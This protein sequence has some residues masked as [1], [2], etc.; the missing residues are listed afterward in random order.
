MSSDNQE[1]NLASENENIVSNLSR[2]SLQ[3]DD[4]IDDL[5]K[6]MST[7]NEESDSE[8][9]EENLMVLSDKEDSIIDSTK[10][11]NQDVSMS[12]LNSDMESSDVNI[13]NISLKVDVDSPEDKLTE[14][15]ILLSKNSIHEHDG[16][17]QSHEN[18]EEDLPSDVQLEESDNMNDCDKEEVKEEESPCEEEKKSFDDTDLNHAVDTKNTTDSLENNQEDT[19]NEK[20][21]LLEPSLSLDDATDDQ[22]D[23]EESKSI[24]DKKDLSLEENQPNKFTDDEKNN[25]DN[26]DLEI[27]MNYTKENKESEKKLESK[28]DHSLSVGGSDADKEEH[29][30][31]NDSNLKIKDEDI[32]NESI[33]KEEALN[34]NHEVNL[35]KGDDISP[36]IHLNE[37][38]A[39][40]DQQNNDHIE[41]QDAPKELDEDFAGE[42]VQDVAKELDKEE[43][44]NLSLD[45][46]EETDEKLNLSEKNLEDNEN[47]LQDE[48]ISKEKEKKESE[49]Q[50]DVFVD[51]VSCCETK[52]EHTCERQADET[53]QS[54]DLDDDIEALLANLDGLDLDN[55]ELAND[56][57]N[58]FEPKVKDISEVKKYKFKICTS[59]ASMDRHMVSR[60]NKIIAILLAQ[61]EITEEQ[62]ELCDIGTD[63]SYKKLWYRK[64]IDVVNRNPLSLPGIFRENGTGNDDIFIGNY[65]MIYDY[66]EQFTIEEHLWPEIQDESNEEE[67]SNNILMRLLGKKM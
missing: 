22:K 53:I 60:T 61:E 59:L 67:E 3:L 26:I 41:D 19:H 65:E 10:E 12:K 34:D 50:T 9:K 54:D 35:E 52:G 8:N 39:E 56:L 51:S 27:D 13:E 36:E 64:A 44:L 2:R 47:V 45:T 57:L 40:K 37:I 63:E 11:I 46:V 58:E 18:K 32:S 38:S 20:N 33:F 48:N 55:D 5:G 6:Y 14:K 17:T 31:V 23:Q 24:D 21:T 42:S 7:E 49:L 28:D 25:T 30:T 66:N 4:V 62:L 29:T 15:E 43:D 16:E 1:E